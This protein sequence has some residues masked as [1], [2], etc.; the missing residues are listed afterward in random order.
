[1]T[2]IEIP[3]FCA[4]RPLTPAWTVL[5][6]WLPVPGLG[7]LPVNCFLLKGPEPLLVD[8]GLAAL[9]DDFIAALETEIDPADLRWIWLSH[10]DPD[11]VGNLSRLLARA[12]QARI[13]TGF[14]G[15]GK[16]QLA[17]FDVATVHVVQP[18]ESF[19]AGGRRLNPLRPPYYDAPETLGFH[20][21]A[22]G[23][24]FAA[25]CFGA[26]LPGMVDATEQIA[27]NTLRDGLLTWTAIDAP[28]LATADRAALGRCLAAFERLDAAWLLSAHLPPARGAGRLTGLVADAYCGR[29][30]AAADPFSIERLAVASH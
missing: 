29:E 19:T 14:L 4:P 21:E 15:M 28:W 16:L 22:D 10:M 25:D 20:D 2:A 24:L 23:V 26:V 13:V 3:T 1:M 11:H 7:A 27:A 30:I 12:P 9:G 8:T 5:P 6:S 18:G 17:G